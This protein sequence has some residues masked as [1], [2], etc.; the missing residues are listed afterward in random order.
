MKKLI[1]TLFSALSVFSLS[2]GASAVTNNGAA[3]D[4]VGGVG[5]AVENIAEGAGNAVRGVGEGVGDMLGANNANNRT[6][7]DVTGNQN[8]IRE[9]ERVTENTRTDLP[10]NTTT[11]EEITD[12]RADRNPS[13]GVPFSGIAMVSVAALGTAAVA[14]IKKRK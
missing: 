4:V 2:L 6:A 7:N 9:N 10:N 5:T 12:R 1:I 14:T 3:A 13:T 11:A 8:T